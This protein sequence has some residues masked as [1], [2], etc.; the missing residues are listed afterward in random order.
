MAANSVVLE[1]NPTT[2]PKDII[3]DGMC[4][5]TTAEGVYHITG[6]N[7][8]H[9]DMKV[10]VSCRIDYIWLNILNKSGKD[11]Y[12]GDEKTFMSKNVRRDFKV[13]EL[14]EVYKDYAKII[15]LTKKIGL[16][17]YWELRRQLEQVI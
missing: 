1:F 13:G 12:E 4:I 5:L 16:Y 8:P 3:I 15:S 9:Y 17:Q 11:L 10:I 14:S 2:F 7:S 6:P